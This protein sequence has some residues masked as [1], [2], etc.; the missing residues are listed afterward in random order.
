MLLL[1]KLGLHS[2]A[3]GEISSLGVWLLWAQHCPACAL[4]D[5]ALA[6]DEALV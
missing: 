5:G 3:A 6:A 1:E 2:P 4:R